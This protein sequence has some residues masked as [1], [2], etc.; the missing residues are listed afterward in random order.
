MVVLAA[1]AA[2]YKRAGSYTKIVDTEEAD[3]LL[4]GYG[5]SRN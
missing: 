4:A 2:W 5:A 3:G 1:Y